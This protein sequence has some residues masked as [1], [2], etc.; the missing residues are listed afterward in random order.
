MERGE[1]PLKRAS[2]PA[3]SPS[4]SI[5]SHRAGSAPRNKSSAGR[6]KGDES[7]M[8][9]CARKGQEDR[10]KP[11][12]VIER[13]RARSVLEQRPS[14]IFGAIGRGQHLQTD[15]EVLRLSVHLLD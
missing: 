11:Q 3:A 13:D 10:E 1:G 8:K 15:P 7:G 14:Q 12:R 2:G 6:G 5:G 9:R 4:Q